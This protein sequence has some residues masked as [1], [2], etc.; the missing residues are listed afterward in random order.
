MP[1]NPSKPVTAL[2]TPIR[3]IDDTAISGP[4]IATGAAMVTP[5]IQAND[6]LRALANG[7]IDSVQGTTRTFEIISKLEFLMRQTGTTPAAASSGFAA[8]RA[9]R[10]LRQRDPAPLHRVGIEQQQ[11]VNQRLALTGQNQ[12]GLY[13]LHGADHADHRPQHAFELA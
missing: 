12:Q 2:S 11:P 3:G 4:I 13:R 7:S 5:T 1:I 6:E 9:I 10:I 8:N